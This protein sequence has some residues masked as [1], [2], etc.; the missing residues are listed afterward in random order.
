[1]ACGAARIRSVAAIDGL[2]GP[3]GPGLAAQVDGDDAGPAIL[4][5]VAGIGVTVADLVEGFAGP[6]VVA[7]ARFL[8]ELEAKGVGLIDFALGIEA[9]RGGESR[10]CE[11]Q[12]EAG[13]NSEAKNVTHGNT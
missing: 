11:G 10:G 3:E 9:G 4:E 2:G 7:E 6:V 5:R 1:M 13:G 8:A 12:R